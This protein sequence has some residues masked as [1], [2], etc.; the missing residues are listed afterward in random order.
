MKNGRG[1]VKKLIKFE[2]NKRKKKANRH[3][4]KIIGLFWR[5]TAFFIRV[6]MVRKKSEV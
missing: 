1:K 5:K 3:N 2:D 4:K 6:I